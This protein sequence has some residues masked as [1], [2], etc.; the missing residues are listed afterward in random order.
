MT[1]DVIAR[2]PVGTGPQVATPSK[3][4]V[5]V[6]DVLD[7]LPGKKGKTGPIKEVPDAESLEEIYTTIRSGGKPVDSKTYPGTVHELPDGTI[8][9]HRPK[10]KSGGAT[11]DVTLPDHTNVKV[12]IKHE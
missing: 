8:V 4:Q 6:K 11:L 9:R 1:A 2:L 10:S 3:P 7:Q 5:T 12:H